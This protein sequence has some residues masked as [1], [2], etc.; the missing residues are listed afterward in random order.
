M[1]YSYTPALSHI[2]QVIKCYKHYKPT[3]ANIIS[4]VI[5]YSKTFNPYTFVA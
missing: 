4:L 3:L 2:N 1:N 5:L